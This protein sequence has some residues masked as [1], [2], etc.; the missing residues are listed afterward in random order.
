MTTLVIILAISATVAVV[1]WFVFQRQN[2]EQSATRTRPATPTTTSEQL[3]EG[4]DRPTGPDAE[5]MDSDRLG[6]DHR[7][8]S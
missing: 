3:Y 1:S 8:R 7:P 6:G 2:P 5:T 4:A